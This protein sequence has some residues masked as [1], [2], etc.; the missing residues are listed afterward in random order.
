M[1]K[2]WFF[3]TAAVV[4]TGLCLSAST[5]TPRNDAFAHLAGSERLMLDQL[6]VEDLA[7]LKLLH[8][9]RHPAYDTLVLGNSRPLPL[10][11][12]DLGM[13]PDQMFNAALTGESLRSTALLLEHLAEMGRLPHTALIS[14]DHAELNYYGNPQ[15]PS[16]GLRW[17]QLGRDMAA[18]LTRPDIP[19]PDLARMAVRHAMTEAAILARKVNAE[20]VWRG[21]EAWA[22]AITGGDDGLAPRSLDPMA[23]AAD[24]SRPSP[25]RDPPYQPRTLNPPNRNLL[26][27]YL[28]YDLERLAAMGKRGTRIIIFETMLHPALHA[29]AM[30]HPSAVA[31]ES[32]KALM[33][34]C[35]RHGIECHPAPASYVDLGEPWWDEGHP[36]ANILAAWIR[37]FPALA[38]G[39]AA[40]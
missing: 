40:P 21:M 5:P 31:A 26:P 9:E 23:Y 8:L 28:D 2:P 35:A 27:G 16:A 19:L 7:A 3:L 6:P 13:A 17:K 39:R 20:R 36:P 34:S 22:A 24:G 38:A 14:F 37:T 1:V 12:T 25:L 32:R 15:W 18:G 11:A 10:T 30:A 4:L 29:T 33:E